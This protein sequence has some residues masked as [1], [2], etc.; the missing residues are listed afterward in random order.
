MTTDIIPY[1]Y[2]NN[3]SDMNDLTADLRSMARS[4]DQM[5]GSITSL[6]DFANEKLE[7][8]MEYV[9]PREVLIPV[10]I[11]GGLLVVGFLATGIIANVKQIKKK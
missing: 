6:T 2:E 11:I 10:G 8:L 9:P 5:G 7:E 1:Q 4:F 3:L